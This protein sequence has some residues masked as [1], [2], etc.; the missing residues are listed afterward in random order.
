[1]ETISFH[2]NQSSYPIGTKNIIILSPGLQ[3]LYVKSGK[4]RLHGFRGDVVWKCWRTKMNGWR[5]PAYTISSPM[6]LWLRWANNT[7]IWTMWFYNLEMYQKGTCTSLCLCWAHSF[8]WFC[9]VAAHVTFKFLFILHTLI[10]SYIYW[11][12]LGHEFILVIHD[13]NEAI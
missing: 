5:M 12:T 1:M 6:S 8:C 10:H 4:N 9:K 11:T 7:K 2:S 3:M 13:E